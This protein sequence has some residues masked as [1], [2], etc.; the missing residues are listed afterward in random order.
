M[1][2]E[3]K[4]SVLVQ[5]QVPELI[6]DAQNKVFLTGRAKQAINE[7]AYANASDIQASDDN[8][9]AYQFMRSLATHF[10]S[11]KALLADYIVENLTTVDNKIKEEIDNDG[12]LKIAFLMPTNFNQTSKDAMGQGI[13]DYL[14]CKMVAEWYAINNKEDA[15]QYEQRAIAD[16]EFVRRALYKRVRPERPTY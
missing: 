8:E 13:H 6:Y 14:V 16:Y 12:V 11:L 5:L 1:P 15:G 4:I 9:D 10:A 2:K 7:G 3:R